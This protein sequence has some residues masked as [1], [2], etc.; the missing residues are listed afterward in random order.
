MSKVS[1]LFRQEVSRKAAKAAS[2]YVWEQENGVS[3]YSV[4]GKIFVGCGMGWV[5]LSIIPILCKAPVSEYMWMFVL[6]AI[7]VVGGICLIILTK[8]SKRFQKW[9]NKD[10]EKSLVEREKLKSKIKVGKITLPISHGDV[11]AF[12]FLGIII[13]IL[14]VVLGIGTLQGWVTW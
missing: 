11:L 1:D 3:V 10:F 12:K 5:V 13:V 14:I 8:K 7:Q 4:A 2:D 9:A 6:A